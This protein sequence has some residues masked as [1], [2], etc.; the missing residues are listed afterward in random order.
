[1]N[2]AL[3]NYTSISTYVCICTFSIAAKISRSH[4]TVLRGLLCIKLSV[5]QRTRYRKNVNETGTFTYA[6][7]KREHCLQNWGNTE[8]NHRGVNGYC[9]T[10]AHLVFT[11]LLAEINKNSYIHDQNTIL[12]LELTITINIFY[13]QQKIN[14]KCHY[15]FVSIT[16]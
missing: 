2:A 16:R 11:N 14:I 15:F 12:I 8:S 7:P 10:H 6:C 5:C 9:L 3:K 1:M 13:L 4:G